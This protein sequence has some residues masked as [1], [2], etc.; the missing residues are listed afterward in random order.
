[1]IRA[2]DAKSLKPAIDS[3]FPLAK[4]ADA[5]RYEESWRHFGKIVLDV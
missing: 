5:Y 4:I 1:M 2:I 3:H